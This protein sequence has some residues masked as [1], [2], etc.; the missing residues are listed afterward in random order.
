MTVEMVA[1]ETNEDTLR[2]WWGGASPDLQTLIQDRA[3]QL[4]AGGEQS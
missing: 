1:A 4:R 3:A 2:D